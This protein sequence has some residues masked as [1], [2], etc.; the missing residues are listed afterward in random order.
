VSVAGPQFP[1]DPWGSTLTSEPPPA[2]AVDVRHSGRFDADG[3]I[4]GSLSGAKIDL[5]LQLPWPAGSAAGM[6]GDEPVTLTWNLQTSESDLPHT[7]EGVV[8]TQAVDL[9]GVFR[10]QQD[11]LRGRPA[12]R[13]LSGGSVQ[14]T[15]LGSHLA[16]TIEPTTGPFGDKAVVAAGTLGDHQFEIRAARNGR[17][18]LGDVAAV[19]HIRGTYSGQAVHLD[20]TST[21]EQF[22]HTDVTGVSP[23]PP[24]FSALLIAALLFFA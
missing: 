1:D 24:P 9:E 22:G 4:R 8:G 16:V 19:G 14:G 6:L 20:L 7:L 12:G 18:M 15:L 10:L 21:A 23:A 11:F 17:P 13:S 3:N 5:T 2:A